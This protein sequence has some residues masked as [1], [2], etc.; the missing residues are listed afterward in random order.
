LAS[1][2]AGAREVDDDPVGQTVAGLEAVA[3]DGRH[4]QIRAAPR[5]AVGPDL[6]GAIL[7]SEWA[8]AIPLSVHLVVRP[9]RALHAL[10]YRFGAEADAR[11]ALAWIRG[12]GARPAHAR[13]RVDGDG[14]LLSIWLEAGALLSPMQSIVTDEARRRGGTVS[15]PD[16]LTADAASPPPSP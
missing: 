2:C 13:V 7:A 10:G 3:L 6:V 4:L 1:T 12:R 11:R 5:R 16:P 9:P 14:A 8:L 15:E